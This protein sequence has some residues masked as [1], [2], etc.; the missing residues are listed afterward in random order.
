MELEP[1]RPGSDGWKT[2][3]R[4]GEQPRGAARCVPP[5]RSSPPAAGSDS[6]NNS[7][8][9]GRIPCGPEGAGGQRLVGDGGRRCGPAISQCTWLQEKQRPAKKFPSQ[10]DAV[11]RRGRNTVIGWLLCPSKQTG[12]ISLNPGH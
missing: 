1:T 6:S 7:S 10:S 3:W 8:V 5:G 2:Q 9:D 12:C 11:V 4:L